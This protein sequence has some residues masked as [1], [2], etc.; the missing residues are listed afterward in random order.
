MTTMTGAAKPSISLTD[1]GLM[2]ALSVFWGVSF[3]FAKVAVAEVPPITVSFIRII[4]AALLLW[5]V[6]LA[7]GLRLPRDIA[8]WKAFVPLSLFNNVIPFTAMY[9]AQ[10]HIPSGLG[11]IL[12]ATTPFF[13]V[14]F[15][16]LLTRD[17]RISTDRLVGLIIGFTGVVVMIGPDLLSQIG[18]DVLAQGAAL[19]AA[20]CFAFAAISGRRFSGVPPVTVATGQLILSCFILAPAS[21]L[22]DSPWTLPAP[23]WNAIWA[24]VVLTVFSTALAYLLF[25]T[26]IARIGAT[27]VLLVTFVQPLWAVTLGALMLGEILSPPQLIGMMGILIGLAAIDGRP[28]RAIRDLFRRN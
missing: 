11:A 4:G 16:A 27:S 9:W 6:M 17:D 18:I 5:M 7:T 24:I 22:V 14:M 21:L 3:V 12:N 2:L 1:W 26:I 20:L 10:L 13:G 25:F 19:L 8:T 28:A 15:T 23:S